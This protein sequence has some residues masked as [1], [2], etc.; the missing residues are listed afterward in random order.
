MDDEMTTTIKVGDRVTRRDKSRLAPG[1]RDCG[2][3]VIAVWT[4]TH[5]EVFGGDCEVVRVRWDA[6]KVLPELITELE[7]RD[8]EARS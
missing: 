2:G 3:T 4:E 7:A 1:E 8:V 5:R 6:T